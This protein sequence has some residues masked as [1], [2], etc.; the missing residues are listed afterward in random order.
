MILSNSAPY[1]ETIVFDWDLTLVDNIKSLHDAICDVFKAYNVKPWTLE[2]YKTKG[3][4]SLR[5]YFP[6][7]FGDSWQEARD[8][9]YSIFEKNHLEALEPIDGAHELLDT[10]S[11][12]P[13]NLYIL[14]NKTGSILRREVKSLNW[15]KYFGKIVGA[16]DTS[17]DKPSEHVLRHVL[18]NSPIKSGPN[19]WFIG[20]S[21]VDMECAS[22]FNCSRVLMSQ[23]RFDKTGITF[24]FEVE[25]LSDMIEYF[26]YKDRNRDNFLKLVES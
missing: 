17:Y 16:N 7:I 11:K 20:D 13:I 6:E 25:K 18:E 23:Y 1:P 10:L 21:Q 4:R 15:E 2:E 12:L 26:Q 19:I 3:L 14:S 5:D 9:F 8:L 24:D 22:H